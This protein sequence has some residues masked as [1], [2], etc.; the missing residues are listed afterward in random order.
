VTVELT[1]EEME[2]L[3]HALKE[4]GRQKQENGLPRDQVDNLAARLEV[5]DRQNRTTVSSPR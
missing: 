1:A 3:L 4:Y 2:L 5:V